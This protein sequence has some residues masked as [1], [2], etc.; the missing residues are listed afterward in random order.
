VIFDEAT[1]RVLTAWLERQRFERRSWAVS[2]SVPRRQRQIG[3]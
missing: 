1:A 2:A 3:S